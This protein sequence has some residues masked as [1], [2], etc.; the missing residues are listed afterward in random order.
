[1]ISINKYRKYIC[2]DGDGLDNG[3][4]FSMRELNMLEIFDDFFYKGSHGGAC[5]GAR[6][7]V[8]EL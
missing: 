1:M 4:A 7:L 5:R 2:N 8:D 6:R 3:L